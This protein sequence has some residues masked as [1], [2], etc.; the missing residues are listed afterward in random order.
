MK[1]K[2]L[3]SLLYHLLHYHQHILEASYN[4]SISSDYHCTLSFT[5]AEHLRGPEQLHACGNIPG[6]TLTL[7]DMFQGNV[8]TSEYVPQNVFTLEQILYDTGSTGSSRAPQYTRIRSKHSLS[9]C[10]SLNYGGVQQHS[11]VLFMRD[12]GCSLSFS[13]YPQYLA[14]YF[15]VAMR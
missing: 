5:E 3:V 15:S 13:S 9:M 10:A 11:V 8:S 6:G 12:E 4:S 14:I 2:L 1:I 7:A